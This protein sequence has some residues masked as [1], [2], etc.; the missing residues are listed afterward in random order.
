MSLWVLGIWVHRWTTA[1]LTT[2]D[3]TFLATPPQP[4][5]AVSTSTA[6]QGWLVALKA[7]SRGWSWHS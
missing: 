4:S 5:A 3:N 6:A 7:A 2:F 1:A